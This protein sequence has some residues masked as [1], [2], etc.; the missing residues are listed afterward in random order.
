MLRDKAKKRNY[1][2][3]YCD[4][5][6]H[7]CFWFLLFCFNVFI[8][9]LQRDISFS[10]FSM[11][12]NT[13]ILWNWY[14]YQP[15]ERRNQSKIYVWYSSSGIPSFLFELFLCTVLKKVQDHK[16]SYIS[17]CH[18]PSRQ[19][20]FQEKNPVFTLFKEIDWHLC[21]MYH[22]MSNG[23]WIKPW[24]PYVIRETLP[25]SPGERGVLPSVALIAYRYLPQDRVGFFQDFAPCPCSHCV[26]GLI[27]GR[28]T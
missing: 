2:K 14:P 22:K 11:L 12:K 17:R 9:S 18:L 21:R 23:T 15:H 25:N 3:L 8:N 13:F 5:L 4:C 7:I 26:A 20:W 19:F 6:I 28:G 24:K 1:Y 16:L 10:F 27:L